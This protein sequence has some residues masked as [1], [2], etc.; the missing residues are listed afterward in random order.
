ML[1]VLE[2]VNSFWKSVSKDRFIKLK[3]S[4]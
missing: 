4:H 3:D 2:V 1:T